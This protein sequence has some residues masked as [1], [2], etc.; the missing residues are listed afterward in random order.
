MNEQN[1][2]EILKTIVMEITEIEDFE[3]DQNFIEDL[4]IDSM[5][6]IEIVARI[7]KKFK[8]TVP[9]SDLPRLTNLHQ[10]CLCVQ[11]IISEMQTA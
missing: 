9:E 2:K 11:E 10:T 8:I 6:T 5:M 4:G 7:E 3:E 1:I